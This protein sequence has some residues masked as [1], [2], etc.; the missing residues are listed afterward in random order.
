MS[1]IRPSRFVHVVYRTRQFDKMIQWY[2]DV[3]DCRV[4]YQNP[5]LAF[6]TYD[7]EHHRIALVNLSAV[8]PQADEA[9]RRG[10][11]GV[12]HVAYTYGSVEDLVEN[13]A[14]LKG[15]GILPYWCIHHGVTMSMYYADP[16]GNQMEMQVDAFPSSDAANDYMNGP[17]FA[18]NPIGVEYDPE[19]V[20]AKVRA[21]TPGSAFL[22]RQSDLPVSP[23]RGALTP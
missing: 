18:T 23:I 19:E 20:L 12:D 10:V 14:Y 3:F 4:Q 1:R 16:D 11:I 5:V 17:H 22:T 8:K 15:K 2:R 7:D 6:L 21:G 13:Y 9:E